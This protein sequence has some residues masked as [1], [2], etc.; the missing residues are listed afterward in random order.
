MFFAA[1]TIAGLCDSVLLLLVLVLS[2]T[3]DQLLL[4]VLTC[5]V[6]FSG[7]RRLPTLAAVNV[8]YIAASG[9]TYFEQQT[10]LT[11]APYSSDGLHTAVSRLLSLIALFGLIHCLR[12]T[13]RRYQYQSIVTLSILFLFVL[14]VCAKF[15]PPTGAPADI[16]RGTTMLYSKYFWIISF[17]LISIKGQS[18]KT[19][20][21]TLSS[22]GFWT[23]IAQY[24]IGSIPRGSGELIDCERHSISDLQHSRRSGIILVAIGCIFNA[25]NGLIP[26]AL[27][28]LSYPF[29][30]LPR[31]GAEFL[32]TSAPLYMLWLDTFVVGLLFFLKTASMVSIAVGLVRFSG[33]HIPLAQFKI[34]RA[35]NFSDLFH[36]IYFYYSETLTYFFYFPIWKFIRRFNLSRKLENG[37]SVFSAIFFGGLIIHGVLD[38]PYLLDGDYQRHLFI[39]ASRLPYLFM[40]ALLSTLSSAVFH[41]AKH[42]DENRRL[43]LVAAVRVVGLFIAYLLCLGL[44]L[45]AYNQNV[46]LTSPALNWQQLSAYIL[47]LLGL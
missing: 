27:G 21:I 6:A 42:R 22:L 19:V 17:S 14:I 23:P 46:G 45:P 12:L 43:S 32:K 18:A 36:R 4:W 25:A 28:Y 26:I 35:R 1:S 30:L 39:T 31:L 24:H 34:W 20:W 13:M 11:L 10:L 5:A 44:A 47:R 37:V 2:G 38:V 16:L 41:R 9:V 7:S 15:L 40:L 33:F 29:S 8:L 3:Q